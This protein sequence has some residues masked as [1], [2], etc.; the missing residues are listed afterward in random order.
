MP[1]QTTG[2]ACKISLVT[3]DDL[4]R[5]RDDPAFRYKLVVSNLPLLLDEISK[6]R[7]VR[8]DAMECKEIREGGQARGATFEPAAADRQP[9]PRQRPRGLTDRRPAMG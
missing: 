5:A 3:D 9:G 2:K 1:H 6:M 8:S 7:A 4:A